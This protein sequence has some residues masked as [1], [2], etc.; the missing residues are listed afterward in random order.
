MSD[1]SELTLSLYKCTDVE[2]Q[3]KSTARPEISD[4][5]VDANDGSNLI[6]TTLKGER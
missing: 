5:D 6:T 1:C 3:L 4:M 2:D